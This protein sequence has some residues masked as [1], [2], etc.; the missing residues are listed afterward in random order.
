MTTSVRA[1]TAQRYRL[2]ALTS[3]RRKWAPMAVAAVPFLLG[4]EQQRAATPDPQATPP[5]VVG[6]G[7]STP[8]LAPLGTYVDTLRGVPI[9]DPYR[10]LEDT[11]AANTRA[12]VASQETFATRVL[13]RIVH[14]DSLTAMY[15]RSYRGAPTLSEVQETPKGLLLK[16]WLGDAPSLH[17]IDR[18][19]TT[20][21]LLTSAADIRAL[22]KGVSW[23][24]YVPSPSGAL[25]AIG[26]TAGGDAGA[27]VSVLNATT[28]AVLPDRI[29]DLLTTFSDTQYEVTWLPTSK[30]GGEAFFYPR[31]WPSRAG[32]VSANQLHRGRQFLH[33]IGSAQSADVPIFGFGVS[34][35]VPFAPEDVATRVRA[36]PGSQWLVASVFRSRRNGSEH[37]VARR[38]AGDSTTP[39]WMPLL[40]IEDRGGY[41]QL[42]R[43]TAWVLAKREA[44]RG[45]VM[46]RALGSGLVPAGP[47][48]IAIPERRGVITAFAVQNDAVYFTERDSRG[49]QLHA[50]PHGATQ[51]RSIALPIS[52]TVRFVPRASGMDGV[53]VSVETWA[54]PPRWFRVVRGGSVVEPI[55]LDD[56][57]TGAAPTTI[58]SEQLEAP[59][60]DGTLVPVSL[61]YDTRALASKARDG[62]A[63]LII[64]AYGGFAQVTNPM[65]DPALQVW[66]SL[67]GVYAYAHVRGG[68]ELGDAWHRAATREHKQR[69]I[70]DMIG[71]VETLIARG[72]TSAGRVAIQGISFGAIVSGLA[73]LQ[74]PELFGAAVYDVGGPDEL[75]A[76]ALDPTSARNIAEIGDVDTPEGIAMLRA[77]SPY[78]VVPPRIAL[79][80]MLV[81][82]A[83]DDYNF[84]TEMLVAKY[85]ARL[86]AA[87]SG[88]RPVVWVRTSGGHRWLSSLS[89]QWAATV[90][91]FLLWQTGAPGFQPARG[92]VP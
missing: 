18:G 77:A 68:G 60:R 83:N 43:D 14:R 81:H 67:G 64:E 12:W 55:S 1:I 45:R 26:T 28:G 50:L 86:Q 40:S 35:A 6:T 46:R 3:L 19:G 57:Y 13:A 56:G 76:A 54:T 88:A 11:S 10:W 78:H 39:A 4:C 30:D 36:A 5:V 31:L 9:P 2:R 53:V 87:N 62:S 75:R 49:V 79:P 85:V 65:Y 41:P 63:P 92:P 48:E 66:T 32:D 20:E 15:E 44:D 29:T 24:K 17:T 74:R 89:P 22:G 71:A 34:A 61:V 72:Y 73:P 37:Y 33:R 84:G 70:D 16:R 27:A 42:H 25:V 7:V 51:V 90:A 38:T 23:R 8:A 59:S 47:W 82:T 58:V 80:T 69:S 21:R 91:S 52:G